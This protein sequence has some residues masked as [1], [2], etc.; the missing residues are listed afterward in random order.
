MFLLLCRTLDVNFA[1]SGKG[2]LVSGIDLHSGAMSAC[3]SHIVLFSSELKLSCW[4][5]YGLILMV[6]KGPHAKVWVT[7]LWCNREMVEA[8][9]GGAEWRESGHCGHVF[10]MGSR[11]CSAPCFL[12]A[13]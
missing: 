6:L 9:E 12:A 4:C 3:R 1:P 7:S 13:T 8:S 10:E 5:C 2:Q 11:T